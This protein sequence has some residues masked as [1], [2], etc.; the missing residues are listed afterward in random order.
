MEFLNDR[1]KPMKGSKILVL[2]VAY[3]ADVD[4]PR[5]SPSF[6]VMEH[7]LDRGTV[8]SYNDP[9][10]PHLPK[11]RHHSLKMDSRPLTP[12]LLADQDCVLILTA[13]SAYDWPWIV[14]HSRLVVDTRN[15]TKDVGEH[16][17]RIRRA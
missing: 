13:H 3:K 6:V 17:D 8:V 15:A 16:R 9:H 7:L 12:E 14:R 1:G 2:G 10:V 4:D 5:E 11:M